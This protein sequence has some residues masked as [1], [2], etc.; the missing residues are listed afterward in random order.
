MYILSDIFALYFGRRDVCCCTYSNV[1]VEGA[2]RFREW[3]FF[4]HFFLYVSNNEIVD[5]VD[6]WMTLE[7]KKKSR[8]SK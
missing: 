2:L 4:H 5:I 8:G 3:F 1:I 6:C 7:R